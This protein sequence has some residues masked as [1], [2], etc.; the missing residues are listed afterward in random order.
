MGRVREGSV[1]GG[2]TLD[3]AGFPA[4]FPAASLPLVAPTASGRPREQKLDGFSGTCESKEAS[5]GRLGLP[6]STR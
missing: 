1:W 4:A 5:L 3:R 6:L 2:W